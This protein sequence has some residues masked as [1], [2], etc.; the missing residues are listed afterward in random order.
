MPA[1]SSI[2]PFASHRVV[3]IDREGAEHYMSEGQS[4]A[5]ALGIRKDYLRRITETGSYYYMH[6]T[7]K[8]CT[9]Y[10][11]SRIVE[12]VEVQ[13]MPRHRHTY[14]ESV[15]VYCAETIDGMCAHPDTCPTNPNYKPRHRKDV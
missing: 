1:M 12:H 11:G 6:N 5:T 8:H 4:Y 9:I 13:P 2:K 3:A 10:L 14:E 15:S 7:S